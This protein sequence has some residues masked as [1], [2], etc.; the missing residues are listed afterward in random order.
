MYDNDGNKIKKFSGGGDESHAAN[1]LRAMRSRKVSDL[2]AD[3]AKGHISSAYCHLGNISYRLGR[4]ASVE[5]IKE[6]IED[7]QAALETF[8][9]FKSH[10]SANS[11]DIEKSPAILGPRLKFDPKTER[12]VDNGHNMDLLANALLTRNYRKPFVVPEE[13]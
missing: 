8:E 13:V 12:F 10:L 5:K 3:I 1:F 4:T 7:D 2:N 9:R 11:V 6:T